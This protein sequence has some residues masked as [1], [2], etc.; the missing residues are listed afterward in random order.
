MIFSFLAIF[1]VLQWTFLNFPPFSVF[2][3]IFLVQKCVFFTFRDLQFS[4][5]ISGPTVCISHFAGVSVFLTILN[6]LPC[7]FLIFHVCQ[8][9]RHVLQ[10]EF[11]I[12]LVGHISWHI[13]GPT[14]A[15]SHFSGF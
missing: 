9:T 14:M 4:Y 2:L 15:I 6:F 13:P 8:V 12:F 1:H 5:H 10:C 7:E 3:A 11:L